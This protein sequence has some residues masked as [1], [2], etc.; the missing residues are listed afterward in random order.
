VDTA[1]DR[2][3]RRRLKVAIP[4]APR[5]A[6]TLM[7][8]VLAVAPLLV[9][10]IVAVRVPVQHV[11]GDLPQS[12]ALDYASR[13]QTGF[14]ALREDY[15]SRIL[16]RE[17]TLV[18]VTRR[19]SPSTPGIGA[20]S[21]P[22]TQLP[23]GDGLRISP[24]SPQER[25][26]V[27]PWRNS[28][29]SISADGSVVAYLT[30]DTRTTGM[31]RAG[32]CEASTPG[33]TTVSIVWQYSRY[34]VEFTAPCGQIVVKDFRSGRTVVA[35]TA[36]DGSLAN[37]QIH[38]FM[39][40]GDGRS[41][42]FATAASN[43]VPGDTNDTTDVFVRD[44]VAGRTE[45]ISVSIFGGPLRRDPELNPSDLGV[46]I[47]QN[48]EDVLGS[49]GAETGTVSH[50][51][52]YVVFES[53]ADDLV[54]GDTRQTMDVFVRDRVLG[55]TQRVS[56]GSLGGTPPPDDT[57]A[58][59]LERLVNFTVEAAWPCMSPNA[60]YVA[61]RSW[62]STLVTGDRNQGSD[63]FV[64]DRHTRGTELVTVS[65]TGRQQNGDARPATGRIFNNPQ[66][67]A[68]KNCV[69]NDGRY[70]VFESSSTNLVEADTNDEWDVFLRDRRARTTRRIS[71]AVDGSEVKAESEY[72]ISKGPP[73][74]AEGAALSP[75]GNFIV[76]QSFAK[77]DPGDPDP[78]SDNIYPGAEEYDLF[79]FDIA[80]NRLVRLGGA[81]EYAGRDQLGSGRVGAA[82]LSSHAALVAFH[83]TNS[84]QVDL[85][86]T[87]HLY[88]WR[89]S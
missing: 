52:R 59:N 78:S 10:S 43:L 31:E 84:Y 27:E 25:P 4:H 62:S 14:A 37:S 63:I 36:N 71:V 20:G 13:F 33:P 30:T 45:L 22:L 68:L 69:S 76:F 70:V 7:G 44:L 26:A 8:I 81:R 1:A 88:R 23:V 56:A 47:D 53:S 60:R 21:D 58:E 73:P 87:V 79:L 18:S 2:I 85:V 17:A 46:P 55:V 75:D 35:S 50:D 16:G 39:L 24:G 83:A 89:T 15:V 54:P 29:P 41:V 74:A 32:A 5:A 11:L 28:S 49:V 42:V 72:W 77:M 86:H 82:A 65:S 9:S 6:L 48:A 51:G 64:Y 3:V 66:G 38:S 12:A 67:Y 40:S 80:A 34:P 57:H 61:F 19:P